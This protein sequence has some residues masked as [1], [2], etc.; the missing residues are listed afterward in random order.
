MK[1]SATKADGGAIAGAVL[2]VTSLL[3]VGCNVLFPNVAQALTASGPELLQTYLGVI[4]VV[5]GVGTL[6]FTNE[7]AKSRDGEHPQLPVLKTPP[8]WAR[9]RLQLTRRDPS[10]SEEE[11]Q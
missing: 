3:A 11:A 2:L 7:A 1:S 10:R 6:C 4:S 5:S 8:F 9:G